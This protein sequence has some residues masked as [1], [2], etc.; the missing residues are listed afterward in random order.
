M[1]TQSHAMK[2]QQTGGLLPLPP[3]GG[4]QPL[5]QQQHPS[6]VPSPHFNPHKRRGGGGGRERREGGNHYHNHNHNKRQRG[7]PY[8]DNHR[9][10]GGFGG[11][12]R[13]RDRGR[14][15]R[16][17]APSGPYFK[18]SFLEDPWAELEGRPKQSV[19]PLPQRQA[20]RECIHEL[21][22]QREAEEK[23]EKE[24]T[25]RVESVEG[26]ATESLNDDSREEK[27]E[28]KEEAQAAKTETEI[29]G[30]EELSNVQQ[31]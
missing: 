4:A 10:G 6:F 3:L 18:A 14:G 22:P 27:E 17:A 30:S 24:E 8:Y 12:G 26:S 16:D 9:R 29:V 28:S 25:K 20:E 19:V 21:A 2:P 11:R 5:H 13:G 7:Q 1:Q 31:Q 15:G 23:N